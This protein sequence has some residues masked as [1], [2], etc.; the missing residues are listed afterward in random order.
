MLDVKDRDISKLDA[1]PIFKPL[2]VEPIAV[3][4]N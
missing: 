1:V 3:Q 4:I 2:N